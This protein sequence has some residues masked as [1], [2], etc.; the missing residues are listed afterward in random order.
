[1]HI[2][3]RVAQQW[4]VGLTYYLGKSEIYKE[5]RDVLEEIDEGIRRM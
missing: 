1:M 4:R 3:A 2:C 5:E